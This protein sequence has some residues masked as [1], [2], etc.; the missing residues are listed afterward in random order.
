MPAP[1]APVAS[2]AAHVPPPADGGGARTTDAAP[3]KDAADA[4]PPPDAQIIARVLH[5][6]SD[7]ACAHVVDN[8]VEVCACTPCDVT[9][10]GR[11]A[12]ASRSHELY[13]SKGLEYVNDIRTVSFGARQTMTIHVT[14]DAGRSAWGG[15]SDPSELFRGDRPY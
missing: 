3:T 14:L 6:D 10:S 13:V 8:G 11:D 15:P 9:Y 2:I 1:D 12:I 5:I 4:S 7:P